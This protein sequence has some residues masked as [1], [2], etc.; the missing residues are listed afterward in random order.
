M[1][2]GD[3]GTAHITCMIIDAISGRTHA[4]ISILF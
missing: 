3:A 2:N 1:F 4:S